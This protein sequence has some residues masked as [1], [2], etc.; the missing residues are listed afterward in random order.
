[1]NIPNM[2]TLLRMVMI[3]FF[4]A[5]YYVGFDGWNYWAAG[6]FIA[7]SVTD[8]LDGMIAR[9]SGCV[10]NFGKLMDPIADKLLVTSALLILLEWGQV[11]ALVCMIL[12]AR[13][14]VISG[15]RMLAASK[16]VVIAAGWTGKVKTV[17]QIVGVA[18]IFLRNPFFAAWGIPFGQILLYI[19]VVLS[20]VSCVEY[21]VKNKELLKG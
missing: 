1:M 18:A 2:L 7:A 21:I 19:S 17:V 15:V 20:I 10:T 8:L 13:E 11:G 14:F 9:R 3:P 5:V 16:S 4:I 6:I 12:I